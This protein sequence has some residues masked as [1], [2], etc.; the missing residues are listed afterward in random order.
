[1]RIVSKTAEES[2]AAVRLLSETA[3]NNPPRKNIIVPWVPMTAK[4]AA[5]YELP[6]LP[7]AR[8][9]KTNARQLLPIS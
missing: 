7:E 5:G 2:L 8:P 1:M 4:P 6:E 9:D 3:I